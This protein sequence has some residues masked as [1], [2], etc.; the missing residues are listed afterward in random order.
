MMRTVSHREL[1]T[2]VRALILAGLLGLLLAFASIVASGAAAAAASGSPAGV[3]PLS[4]T[5][6]PTEEPTEEEPPAEEAPDEPVEQDND[7]VVTDDD[8]FPLWA[9]VLLVV[10]GIA[11]VAAIAYAATRDRDRRDRI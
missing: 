1:S 8:G 9:T 7:I 11:L 6:E 2:G 3:A 10:L 5:A 4:A